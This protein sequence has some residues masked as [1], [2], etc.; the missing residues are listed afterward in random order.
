MPNNVTLFANE[1]KQL[2]NP[3]G[4]TTV[5]AML[6]SQVRRKGASEVDNTTRDG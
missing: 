1:I 4:L 2:L 5:R 6:M 3:Q